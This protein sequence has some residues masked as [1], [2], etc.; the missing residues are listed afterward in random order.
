[1]DINDAKDEI[2]TLIS[3]ARFRCHRAIRVAEI[4]YHSRTETE[5]QL[6]EV[7]GYR[8]KSANWRDEVSER[9]TG[10][11]STSSRS[12]QKDFSS[13]IEPKALKKLDEVNR[14]NN[15][16]IE[17]YIYHRLKSDKWQ[18]L[19]N[20]QDYIFESSVPEFSFE[21]YIDLAEESGLQEDSILEISVFALFNAIANELEAKAKLEIG[22]PD[23]DILQEFKQFTEIFLGVNAD[24]SSY[25]T[26]VEIYRPGKGT[27]AADKG[28]DIGTNF[29][30]MVQ[31]KHVS[32]D[33]STASK[34]ENRAFVGNVVVVCREAEKEVIQKVAEQ[35]GY[36]KVKAVVTIDD[37][38]SWYETAFD[39]Y[40]ERIG[41]KALDALREEFGREFQR[42]DWKI[43]DIDDF[44]DERNYPE[45]SGVWQS[46]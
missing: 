29:G 8:V 6:S 44:M 22:N 11:G 14:E 23:E 37:L 41:A 39:K 4:L 5:I 35:L 43:P 17:S 19:I 45:P 46:K 1:M 32:L 2:D 36:D 12:Y 28:I 42:G 15:G 3:N 7:E 13:L 26:L 24:K 9:L 21:D 40:P 16:I 38:E 10:K 27:Y 30:T 33:G 18:G 34:I 20:A 31:V 25:E